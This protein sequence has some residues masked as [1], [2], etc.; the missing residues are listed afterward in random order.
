MDLT[1]VILKMEWMMIHNDWSEIGSAVLGQY[2]EDSVQDTKYYYGNGRC[3]PSDVYSSGWT[4]PS[5]APKLDRA[6]I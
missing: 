5:Y 2:A 3:A 6:T 4:T 1:T